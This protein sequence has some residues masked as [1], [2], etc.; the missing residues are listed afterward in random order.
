MLIPIIIVAGCTGG[1]NTATVHVRGPE[2]A[3]VTIIEYGD[4]ECPA[5]SMAEP[6]MKKVLE[7]Y[8]TQVKL[9]F[10]DVPIPYHTYAQK[11]SEAAECAGAQG[12]YWE[13]HDKLFENH[14]ALKISD[15][16]QYAVDIGLDTEKFNECLDSGAMAGDVAAD[17]ADARQAGV[18]ATPTFFVNGRKV[19]GVQ[20]FSV[21]QGIINRELG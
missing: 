5:C 7:T 14:N 16:K 11:A 21:W 12:K 6:I 18:D 13:M 17:M 10:K 1:G 8:P 15:L 20:P 3:T 9:I 4:F 2:N 19:V